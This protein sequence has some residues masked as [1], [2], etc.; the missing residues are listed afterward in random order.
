[1]MLQLRKSLRMEARRW[2]LTRD[3]AQGA[4]KR[5]VSKG[6]V[7]NEEH[8]S[9]PPTKIASPPSPSPLEVSYVLPILVASE[10]SSS[11]NYAGLKSRK[12]LQTLIGTFAPSQLR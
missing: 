12:T 2:M 5:G 4:C 7:I 9:T 1:M 10:P 8:V 3:R 6:E 11:C